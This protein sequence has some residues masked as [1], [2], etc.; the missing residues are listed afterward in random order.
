MSAKKELN[1]LGNEL[2]DRYTGVFNQQLAAQRKRPDQ[3]SEST[4]G[5]LLRLKTLFET[6]EPGLFAAFG[7]DLGSHETERI[8]REIPGFYAAIDALVILLVNNSEIDQATDQGITLISLCASKSTFDQLRL[9]ASSIAS[10][11]GCML[12]CSEMMPAVST[13]LIEML[14]DAFEVADLYCFAGERDN[15]KTLLQL[16]F[17]HLFFTGTYQL[18]KTV[19]AAAAENL[20]AVDLSI[21]GQ[22]PLIIDAHTDLELAAQQI[23]ASKFL[24]AGQNTSSP[25]CIFVH[26]DCKNAFVSSLMLETRIF[27]KENSYNLNMDAYAKITNAG[28]FQRLK[29][30]LQDAVKQGA[31]IVMGGALNAEE[32]IFHPTI[33]TDVPLTCALLTEEVFGPILPIIAYQEIEEVIDVLISNDRLLSPFSYS[34]QQKTEASINLHKKSFRTV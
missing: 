2:K 33:L 26:E 4:L 17:N 3:Q 1:L 5:K 11:N 12:M 30:L 32:L 15:L 8:K 23:V 31:A 28:N 20:A 7:Q 9:L 19:L 13:Y 29:L 25:D 22:Q 18:G 14:N 16:P 27:Y 34:G 24:N 21:T 6:N 10:G